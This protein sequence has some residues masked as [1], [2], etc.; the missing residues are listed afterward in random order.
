[1]LICRLWIWNRLLLTPFWK[2][3]LNCTYI[4][5]WPT[6]GN[7]ASFCDICLCNRKSA[8]DLFDNLHL[9][10]LRVSKCQLSHF[11]LITALSEFFVLYFIIEVYSVAKSF[12]FNL[13]LSLLRNQ[14]FRTRNGSLLL[15]WRR[16]NYSKIEFYIF[17]LVYSVQMQTIFKSTWPVC[18]RSLNWAVYS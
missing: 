18:K 1:M 5:W 3:F 8:S 6:W 2:Q 16:R 10:C 11:L 4:I 9:R 12:H 14:R 15:V 17:I 7:L 13:D